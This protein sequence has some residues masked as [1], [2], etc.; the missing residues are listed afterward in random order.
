MIIRVENLTKTFKTYE[1]GSTFGEAFKSLFVRKPIYV[2]A[3]KGISFNIEAGELIGFLGPNGA[4][5]STTLKILTGI[6]YPSSG[7]VDIMGFTPWKHRKKYVAKIGA[8]FGQKSQL[9][10][11]IPPLDAF[12]LNKAIYSIP[13]RD[14]KR[15]MNDL[16]ELLSLEE[17]I[18]KPTRLLSLGER[19]KCEFVMAMLHKPEIVFLDEPTIGLD[20]IAKDKIREFILEMNRNGV[21]FILTTHDLGDVEHLAQRV[22]VVNHGEI[23]FD[24]SIDT[25]RSHLGVKKIIAVST[26]KPLPDLNLTGINIT[27]RISDYK[28][29]LELDLTI[30]ELNKFIGMVNKTSIISDL[31]VQEPQIDNVIKELY[32]LKI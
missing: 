14:F 2:D 9:L 29:E 32:Q 7:K 6:L 23:V 3:I 17:L 27:N 15:T 1:R 28:I 18:R 10:W 16:V 12:Y 25:L 26:Q 4:G 24:N 11:D 31:S 8:V 21:T 5:K 22:I 19:M 20:V 13:E 30:Y